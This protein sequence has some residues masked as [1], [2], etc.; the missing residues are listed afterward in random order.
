MKLSK[1]MRADLHEWYAFGA[2]KVKECQC[3]VIS[4]QWTQRLIEHHYDDLAYGFLK[5]DIGIIPGD[6]ALALVEMSEGCL[7]GRDAAR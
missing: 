2:D 1:I 6:V 5:E 4:H 3:P 7:E